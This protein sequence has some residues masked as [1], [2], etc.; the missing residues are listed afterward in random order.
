MSPECEASLS[1]K[2]ILQDRAFMLAEA[3]RFFASR[4]VLEVDCPALSRS[5]PIDTHIEVFEVVSAGYL[6]TSP[7]Y[8]MKRLLSL[9][10]GDIYQIS[11]VFRKEETGPLHHPEF[12]MAE[13]YRVGMSFDTLIEETLDFIRLFLGPL[14]AHA[15]TYREA[16]WHYAEFDY[17]TMTE[18]DLLHLAA[19][20]TI[21]LSKEVQEADRDTLLQLLMSLLVEPH[22]GKDSLCVI[23]DFPASQAALAKTALKND[24]P[25]A[26]RFEVYCKGIELANG[27]DE[28]TDLS[29]QRRRLERSNAQ[30]VLLGKPALKIDEHFLAALERG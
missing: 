3:R 2:E 22:L 9:N 11:H 23:T 26:M 24:E 18:G 25:I 20:N 16:L 5:A 15:F 21:S 13:W 14:P 17:L 12:T 6:H 8:G 19:K 30:R 7:E 10:S 4:D 29:E 27:Y 1:K 28:L